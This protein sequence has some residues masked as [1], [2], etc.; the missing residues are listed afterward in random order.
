MRRNMRVR[1]SQRTTLAT[2]VDQQRQVAP[3]LH[4]ARHRLAD[5]RLGRRADDQRLLE[6]ALRVGYQL[7]VDCLE[8]MVRDHRHLLGKA[9]DMTGFLGEKAERNEQR[10]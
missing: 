8:A 9:V 3:A 7:A 6:L 2:L 5:H 4:P 10:K 1:I